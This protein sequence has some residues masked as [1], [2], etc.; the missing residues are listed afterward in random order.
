MEHSERPWENIRKG[1]VGSS[2]SFTVQQRRETLIVAPYTRQ[3]PSGWWVGEENCQTS[4][5]ARGK[6]TTDVGHGFYLMLALMADS[7]KSGSF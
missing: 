1:S 2:G 3:C 7:T 6:E 5:E 4:F